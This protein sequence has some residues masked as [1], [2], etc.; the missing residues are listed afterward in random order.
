MFLWVEGVVSFQRH[1]RELFLVERTGT[2]TRSPF[3]RAGEEIPETGLYRVFHAEHRV[4]HEVVLRTREKFPRC[5]KCNDDVHFEL[6]QAVADIQNDT[7]FIRVYE[8]PH[9]ERATSGSGKVVA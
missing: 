9:P 7:D 4:S 8:I 1:H 5:V 3:F 2:K 6:L